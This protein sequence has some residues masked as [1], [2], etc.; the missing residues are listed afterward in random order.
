VIARQQAKA[1]I[2]VDQQVHSVTMWDYSWLLRR[3]GAEAEYADV[4]K[5]LDE[6]AERGYDVVRIDSFPHWI[7]AGRDGESLSSI[8]STTQPAGFMWGNH[9]D[10]T[11]EPRAALSEFLGLG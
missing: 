4:N 5:V 9:S 6:L 3:Q 7:A 11:V 8:H 2:E 1:G 10:V